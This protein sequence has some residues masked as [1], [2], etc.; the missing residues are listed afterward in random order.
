MISDRDLKSNFLS[1]SPFR[2]ST[3]RILSHGTFL[4]ICGLEL[5]PTDD[6]GCK[7]PL[8]PFLLELRDCS[9][10][11]LSVIFKRR[12]RI[13]MSSTHRDWRKFSLT[14]P[15]IF[16]VLSVWVMVT[17][18]F[19]AMGGLCPRII[20]YYRWWLHART[21]FLSRISWLSVHFRRR[22]RMWASLSDKL[23]QNFTPHTGFQ[24]PYNWL[25]VPSS[26][27]VAWNYHLLMIIASSLCLSSEPC[28]VFF[29]RRRIPM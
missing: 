11:L 28:R 18:S 15:F 19:T 26:P 10:F 9:S 23:E 3:F 8:T 12:I 21:S 5:S 2:N 6:D 17:S 22:M 1:H 14:P 4:I 13:W 24:L 25:M 7:G 29:L 20:A 16:Q 27:S